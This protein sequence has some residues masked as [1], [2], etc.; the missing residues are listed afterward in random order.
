MEPRSGLI[1]G[2]PTESGAFAVQLT[3]RDDTGTRVESLTVPLRV[4]SVLDVSRRKHDER[5]DGADGEAEVVRMLELLAGTRLDVTVKG[6]SPA[7]LGLTVI[8]RDG[9]PLDLERVLR[10]TRSGW[11]VVCRYAL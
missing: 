8:D 7:D 9:Q 2:T 10:R 5:I 1:S 4:A 6:R 11:R 3:A